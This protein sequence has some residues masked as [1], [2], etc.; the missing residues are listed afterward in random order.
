MKTL[1]AQE[2]RNMMNDVPLYDVRGDMDYREEH[3]A[4]AKTA[5]LGSIETRI[6]D[7]LD[8]SSEVIVHCTSPDCELS[9]EAAKRLEDLGHTNV[10]RFEG[11]IEAW[12]QAGFETTSH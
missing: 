10:Y 11:G 12:K 8:N 6:H 5:P 2:V 4:G 7:V 9:Q 1:T 3:I